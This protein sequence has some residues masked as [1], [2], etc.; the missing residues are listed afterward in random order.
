MPLSCWPFRQRMAIKLDHIGALARNVRFKN[1][2]RC[3][4]AIGTRG[5]FRLPRS[6]TN[7]TRLSALA[8]QF[9]HARSDGSEIVCGAGSALAAK[10]LHARSDRRKIRWLI[11]G[12]PYQREELA[13]KLRSAI[14]S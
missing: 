6:S 9:L 3:G 1:P 11:S 12:K 8:A 13:Q 7:C 2:D 4:P 10:L 14:G 5:P